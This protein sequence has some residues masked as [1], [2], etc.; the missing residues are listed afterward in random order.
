M[1]VN[2]DLTSDLKGCEFVF[3]CHHHLIR[4]VELNVRADENNLNENRCLFGRKV[5]LDC[6]AFIAVSK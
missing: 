5:D 6:A 4:V 1:L 3:C 2:S